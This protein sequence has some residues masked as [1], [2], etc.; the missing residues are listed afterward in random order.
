MAG[1][2]A[3]RHGVGGGIAPDRK[4]KETEFSREIPRLAHTPCD[5]RHGVASRNQI[6]GVR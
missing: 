5:G 3:Q 4:H 2:A 6:G 1:T